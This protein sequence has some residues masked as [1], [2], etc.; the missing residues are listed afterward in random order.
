M[1]VAENRSDRC[2]RARLARV[3][4]R[5]GRPA[6]PRRELSSAGLCCHRGEWAQDECPRSSWR[7]R[8]GREFSSDVGT[9]RLLTNHAVVLGWAAPEAAGTVVTFPMTGELITADATCVSPRH[10]AAAQDYWPRIARPPSIAFSDKFIGQST[11][12]PCAILPVSV[13]G[14]RNGAV[15]RWPAWPAG[16]TRRSR[17]APRARRCPP[18]SP[19]SSRH[20]PSRSGR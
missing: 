20:R 10:R 2:R 3:T 19:T 7:A 11:N 18:P 6:S 5:P 1:Q 4:D 9:V 17:R 13:R 14:S 16:G 12:G 8:C 15:R